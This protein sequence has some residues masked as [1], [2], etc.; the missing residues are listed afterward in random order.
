MQDDTLLDLVVA[1]REAA[2]DGVIALT[3]RDT[4][5][6]PLPTWQPGAHVDLVL[7]PSLIR[8]YSL[9]GDPADRDSYR[10]AVLREPNSRGGSIYVHDHLPQGSTV[11]VRGPRNNFK[12]QPSVRYLFIGG[13]IGITPLL[14]MLAAVSS[15]QAQWRL[16]YGGRTRASMAFADQLLARYGDKVVLSPQD[17]NG[18]LDLPSILQEPA[19]ATL[20]YCCGPEPL[21]AAVEQHCASWTRG[22]VHVEHFSPTTTEEPRVNAAFQVEL[23][24]SGKIITIP[25]DKSVLETLQ[26]AGVDVVWGCSDGVCRACETPVIS[27]VV[28]H[29]D[30]VLSPEERAAHDRM[31]ICVSRA[32]CPRLVLRL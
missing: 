10:I 16:I 28:D 21:L 24:L 9:C 18:L 3:L 4:R 25:A 20:V 11:H 19:E 14:P 23:A 27:G 31:M 30:S 17:E 13:G 32:A 15:R 12:L 5:G 7:E 1:E 6:A 26:E 2:A 8:Q 29:R 22:A